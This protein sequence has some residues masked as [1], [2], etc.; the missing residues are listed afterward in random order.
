MNRIIDKGGIVEY[1]GI[2]IR[3]TYTVSIGSSGSVRGG[4]G[5]VVKRSGL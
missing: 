3:A 2:M 4:A 1:T 5:Y